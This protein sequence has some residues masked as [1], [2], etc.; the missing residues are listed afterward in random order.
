[1]VEFTVYTPTYNRAHTLPRVYDCLRN[2]SYKDFIW[3]IV[4]DG[5]TDNTKE[6]VDTWIKEAILEIKYLY[7]QNGGKHTAMELA[8]MNVNTKYVIGLDS[9]DILVYDAIETFYHHW[10]LIEQQ[11]VENEIAEIRAFSIDNKARKIV[12][13]DLSMFNEDNCYI[14]AT[15]QEWYIKCKRGHE[16]I[17]A[18]NTKKLNECV[19]ISKYK[20]EVNKIKFI[21]EGVFW[22]SIGRN[23]KTRFVNYI[24]RIYYQDEV[25]I[26]RPEIKDKNRFY[27]HL[28]GSF[29]LVD[30]NIKYFWYSPSYFIKNIFIFSISGLYIGKSVKNQIREINNKPFILLYVLQYP[31]SYIIYLYIKFIRGL[32]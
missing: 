2:Q 14:D 32:N 26:L 6:L 10:K 18:H 20:Y 3:L 22:S 1:M 23:Y 31:I 12:G 30:E 27:N 7:K 5:S 29:Y 16:M 25:S 9:D 17:M 8:H 4:D 11:G 21:N 15:W 19:L 13:G 28:V 24:A